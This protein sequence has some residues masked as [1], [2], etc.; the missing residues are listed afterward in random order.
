[1]DDLKYRQGGTNI[2][3]ALRLSL[4]EMFQ[5]KNG[6]RSDSIKTMIL[7]TDGKESDDI[8]EKNVAKY[9][10]LREEFKARNIHL[11]V[12]GVGKVDKETLRELVLD[13]KDFLFAEDFDVLIEKLTSQIVYT[14]CP[15]SLSITI[16]NEGDLFALIFS[17][18]LA[19]LHIIYYLIGP[20]NCEWDTWVDGQCSVTCGTG[21]KTN[22]RT[23]LVNEANGGTCPGQPSEI[24]ECNKD[25]CPRNIT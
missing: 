4:D 19:E 20:I 5:S 7:I 24:V 14:V 23:K 1:M 15:G 21:T 11:V 9:P 16:R 17:N 25:P 10:S 12:V 3:G 18:S 22:T 6:M 13:D 8:R 2:A